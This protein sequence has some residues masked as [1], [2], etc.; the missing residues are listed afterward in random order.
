M[1]LLDDLESFAISQVFLAGC[2]VESLSYPEPT[3]CP[4]TP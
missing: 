3:P 2:P 1:I 4:A